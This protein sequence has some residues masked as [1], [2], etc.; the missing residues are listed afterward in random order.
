MSTIGGAYLISMVVADLE[1]WGIR[2]RLMSV[3]KFPKP[4]NQLEP[5]G[6]GLFGFRVKR[7]K[8]SY[9]LTIIVKPNS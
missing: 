8:F 1:T 2:V 4:N 5:Y 6:F 7:F 9:S 3:K